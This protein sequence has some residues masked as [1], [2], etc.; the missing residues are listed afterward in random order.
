MIQQSQERKKLERIKKKDKIMKMDIS[1]LDMISATYFAN[2]KL[3][4]IQKRCFNF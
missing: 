2:R 3:E 4:I 1:K